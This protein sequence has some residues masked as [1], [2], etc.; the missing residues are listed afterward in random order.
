[1][2]KT[3]KIRVFCSD[4]RKNIHIEVPYNLADNRDYY[5]FEY[6]NIHGSPEHA[7]MIFFDAHLSIR[8]AMVY[9]DIAFAKKQEKEFTNLVRMSEN[10][11][12]LSIYS[13]QLRLKLYKL[14]INGP[15]T[16]EGL[17]QDLSEEIAFQDQNFNTLIL[18]LIKSGLVRVRWISETFFECYFLMKDFLALRV[19]FKNPIRENSE[20]NF[21]KSINVL[22][23]KK[24]S[25]FFQEYRRK[26]LTNKEAQIEETKNCLEI[27]TNSDYFRIIRA[28]RLG[29]KT[30]DELLESVEL[31]AIK[32][33][34]YKNI[35][36]E[37][38]DKLTTY[39][40]L[41]CDIKVS[42]FIPTYMLNTITQKYKN[43]E[44]SYEMAKTHLD[45]LYESN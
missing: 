4:C 5:P 26:L 16:E 18:P 38:K 12:L 13:D 15:M 1:M 22:F 28:L 45:L 19:P 36:F 7:L 2:V 30:L 9:Q 37:A 34:V 35:I 39:Y 8:D 20:N 10:E 24:Q 21:N 11:A 14:L 23:S 44:I 43:R 17:I 6:I 32:D 29:T 42:K 25:K 27:L 31:K 3:K 33:L 41:I 40:T